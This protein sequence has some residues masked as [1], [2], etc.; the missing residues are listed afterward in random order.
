[1]EYCRYRI[2]SCTVPQPQIDLLGRLLGDIHRLGIPSIPWPL[3]WPLLPWSD[4]EPRSARG[5]RYISIRGWGRY[6]L[7]EYGR[8]PRGT[9]GYRTLGS[10]PYQRDELSG[11][12][13]LRQLGTTRRARLDLNQGMDYGRSEMAY[14]STVSP[15]VPQRAEGRRRRDGRDRTS[16]RSSRT[17]FPCQSRDH[18][19][20]TGD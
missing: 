20:R 17:E 4:R 19:E 15:T 14:R 10:L 8:I 12:H 13:D 2:P 5:R 16:Q 9:R 7:G 11:L 1:M 6:R 3:P 18:L